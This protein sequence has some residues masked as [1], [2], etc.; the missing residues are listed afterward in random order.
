[1]VPRRYRPDDPQLVKADVG[2]VCISGLANKGAVR[3]FDEILGQRHEGAHPA[4]GVASGGTTLQNYG[5]AFASNCAEIRVR[6]RVG[7]E[8]DNQLI[9]PVDMREL[10]VLL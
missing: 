7:A 5:V 6:H 10:Q 9:E 3:R 2:R 4:I 8:W 1:M